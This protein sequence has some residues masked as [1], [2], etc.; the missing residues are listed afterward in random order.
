MKIKSPE[1]E[2]DP[3]YFK[4]REVDLMFDVVVNPDYRH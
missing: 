4:T 1:H 2:Y 3:Q